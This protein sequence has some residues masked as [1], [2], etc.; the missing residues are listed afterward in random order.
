M[1]IEE[2]QQAILEFEKTLIG[3]TLEELEKLEDEIIAEADEIDKEVSEEKYDLPE[4][5]YKE[6]AQGIRMF[7]DKQSVEW[8]YTLGMI[9]MYD[10]WNPDEKP[11]KIPYP[12]LD[13]V[14]RTLGTLRFTG[15][16]E[17]AAVI[18]IN[19]YFE[20]LHESYKNAIE[21]ISLVAAKHNAII[22]Q[23]KKNE[24]IG[25]VSDDEVLMN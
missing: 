15:H 14:M 5:N 7:L 17:W 13:S 21:K 12:Q 11:E 18:I 25:T 19:K 23:M 22:D 9:S 3:K 8:Q 4:K 16:E 6:V 24:P 20:P 10:F 1:T 2:R